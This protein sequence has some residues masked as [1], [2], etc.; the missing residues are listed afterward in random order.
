MSQTSDI[1]KALKQMSD[2]YV[3][4]ITTVS[5]AVADAVKRGGDKEAPRVE[6]WLR[7]ARMGKDGFVTAV[8]QGFEMWE[9]EMRRTLSSVKREVET[10]KVARET[11]PPDALQSFIDNWNEASKTFL[12][13]VGSSEL[14]KEARK[15]AEQF[16]S[17]MRD[18][19]KAWQK[20]W[21]Q[22]KE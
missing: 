22:S 15:Q 18:S 2:A 7:L 3:E 9:R 17:T 20:M 6:Y 13:T 4:A 16:A 5:R 21:S 1:A 19:L 12:D 14:G 8:E 10:E 11:R